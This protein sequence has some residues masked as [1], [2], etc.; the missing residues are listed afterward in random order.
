MREKIIL[1]GYYGYG[2][3]GDDILMLTTY[4][5][6]R[7]NFP[8]SEI[9][10]CTNSD[11]AQYISAL[12]KSSVRVVKSNENIWGD[13]MIDGGGGIYFDFREAGT[14]YRLLNKVIRLMTFPL[15]TK[16]Y[17]L[18]RSLRGNNGVRGKK[19]AGIGIGIGRYTPSSR[20][21][22]GD[23]VD[24]TEYDFLMVRD[25]ESAAHFRK[26]NQRTPLHVS[27]DLAFLQQYWKKPVRNTSKKKVGFILRDWA[28][29]DARFSVLKSVADQLQAEGNAICFYSF[30]KN[31]DA[32]YIKDFSETYPFVVWDPYQETVDSFKEKL[33]ECSL[34]ITS[35]AHG[36]IVSACI[37]VPSLCLCIEPKLEKISQMLKRSSVL[38]RQPFT[39]DDILDRARRHLAQPAD[40]QKK[41]QEDVSENAALI[42]QGLQAFKKYASEK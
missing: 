10:I 34:V 8:D 21:F 4:G 5:W 30:D 28:Y 2:N 27:T 9:L 32:N 15:Y 23:I 18:Y 31:A 19:R 29:E 1:R 33:A 42:T 13:W 6:V 3:L 40:L 20:R 14:R 22:Y 16:L 36:A 24:I 26:L 12:L 39:T 7:D 41:V 25:E 17:R 37:G 35:R 11:R 38:I